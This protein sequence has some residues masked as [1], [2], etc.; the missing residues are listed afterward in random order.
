MKCSTYQ[1]SNSSTHNSYNSIPLYT[2][3]LQYTLDTSTTLQ[4]HIDQDYPYG[5]K[6]QSTRLRICKHNDSSNTL[7]STTILESYS[8]PQHSNTFPNRCASFPAHRNPSILAAGQCRT[9]C[10]RPPGP[11]GAPAHN[12]LCLSP[13][14]QPAPMARVLA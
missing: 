11:L 6:G 9:R 10:R 12:P 7:D 4:L 8:C 13:A 3:L 2:V 14:P 1:S 5:D